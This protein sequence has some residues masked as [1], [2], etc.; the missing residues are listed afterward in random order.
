MKKTLVG[1]LA[2]KIHYLLRESQWRVM[3]VPVQ[4]LKPTMSYQQSSN[5]IWGLLQ[6]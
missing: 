1:L 4:N 3:R 2:R 5:W 6:N